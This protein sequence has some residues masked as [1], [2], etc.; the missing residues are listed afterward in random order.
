MTIV[1]DEHTGEAGIQTRLE[2]FMDIV[3]R[4]MAR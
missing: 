4:S 2:A 1:V 3:E